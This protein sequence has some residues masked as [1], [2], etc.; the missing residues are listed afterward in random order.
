MSC[1][2]SLDWGSHWDGWGGGD[3]VGWCSGNWV[4]WGGNWDGS[5]HMGDG[6]HVGD[7]GDVRDDVL[8]Q[9]GAWHQVAVVT[10]WA[11]DGDLAEHWRDDWAVDWGGDQAT[12]LVPVGSCETGLWHIAVRS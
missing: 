6:W 12:G 2:V 4:S 10:G 9:W 7:T 3:W 5:G 11:G 1:L 8:D